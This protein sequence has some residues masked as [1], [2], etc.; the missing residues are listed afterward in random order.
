MLDFVRF[1]KVKCSR[2]ECLIEGRARKGSLS[3]L[4]VSVCKNLRIFFKKKENDGL[5]SE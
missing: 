3:S 2:M 4:K 5:A 1:L